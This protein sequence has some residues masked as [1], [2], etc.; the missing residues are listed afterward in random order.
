MSVRPSPGLP[1]S[2]GM[3][4]W[5]RTRA[6]K[7]LIFLEEKPKRLSKLQGESQRLINQPVMK[8]AFLMGRRQKANFAAQRARPTTLQP[9]SAP[10]GIFMSG[11][12]TAVKERKSD[13]VTMKCYS[14]VGY[15]SL[16]CSVQC[17]NTSKAMD[18]TH[19]LTSLC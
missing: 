18:R 10:A 7:A 9:L 6:T 15:Y 1:I 3:M 8:A 16:L 5:K 13:V 12:D 4:R 11:D 2:Y 19:K 14:S 17:D